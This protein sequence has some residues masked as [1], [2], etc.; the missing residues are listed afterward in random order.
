[1]GAPQLVE[2]TI[3]GSLAGWSGFHDWL[4]RWA[5]LA[6]WSVAAGTFALAVATFVLASRARDEAQAVR[7]EATRVAEQAVASLRAYVYP[8]ASAEFVWAITSDPPSARGVLPLR[9]GGPGIAFNVEGVVTRGTQGELVELHAGSIAPGHV[10][11][12]RPSR[13]FEGGWGGWHGRWHG[14]VRYSDLNDDHWITRFTIRLSDG[15]EII[16]Q[17]EPPTRVED[18]MRESRST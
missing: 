5:P 11:Q 6:E 18:A 15:E 13:P 7:D 9:N 10:I 14:E 16:I 3:F 1:M 12:A 8:E 17:H 2:I 4:E